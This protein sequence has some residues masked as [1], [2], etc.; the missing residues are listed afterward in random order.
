MIIL[1]IDP[2]SLVT[3]Y[4]LIRVEKNQRRYIASGVIATRKAPLPE[5]LRTI[6]QGI[7][8]LIEQYQ[9]D[10]FAV[11]Q[12]FMARNPD[13]ALKLGQARGAAICAASLEQRPIFEYAAREVKLAVV[14]TG[15]AEKAQVAHMVKVLL[16]L[17]GDLR[18]DAADALAVAL[19][20]ANTLQLNQALQRQTKPRER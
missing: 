1:G 14:G 20:H 8:Q 13:S 9:P 19:C 17:S 16:A 12:V 18:S 10:H 7:R 5:R 2:G 15:R 4:G 11:E 3:G 6:F